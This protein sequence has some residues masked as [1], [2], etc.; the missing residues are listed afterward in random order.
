LGITAET[1]E[2]TQGQVVWTE[3]LITSARVHGKFMAVVEKALED[4]FRSGKKTQLLPHMPVE[5]RK[6]VHDVR[7]WLSFLPPL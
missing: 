1:R 3:E 5:R 2:K 6:F 4:F 7:V